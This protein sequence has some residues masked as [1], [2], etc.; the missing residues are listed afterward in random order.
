MN[1]SFHILAG[2]VLLYMAGLAQAQ[3]GSACGSLKNH[4]GPF[5]YRTA[6]GQQKSLVED[7]H[8]TPSIE[9]LIKD[10]DNPFANDISY[11]LRVF[12]NHP[13]AL[14]TMQRLA[15]REKVDKPAHA[16]WPMACYYQRA[17]Q[18]QPKD[19]MPR[20]LYADYLA[21][22]N[23][24]AEATRQLDEVIRLADDNPFTHYNVGLIFLDMKNYERALVQAHRAE[25]LGLP[26]TEIKDRLVAEGKWVD[27]QPAPAPRAP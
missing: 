25:E 9:N 26:R 3:E 22:R 18:F 7:N 10:H 13:R 20:M 15:D 27:P 4:D 21:K 6:N 1:A 14:I 2:V 5:D 19:T 11:T 23:Q 24:P 8:F 12:P 17:I 16:Q